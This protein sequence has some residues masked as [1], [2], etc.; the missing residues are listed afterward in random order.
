MSEALIMIGAVLFYTILSVV[1]IACIYIKVESFMKKQ[2]KIKCLCK[3]EYTIGFI[4]Q[5]KECTDYDLIC[6]KCKKEK[7]IRIFKGGLFEKME[8]GLNDSTGSENA[9]TSNTK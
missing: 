3:H 2:S 5:G 6:R 1:L 4:W 8:V 9:N 7:K